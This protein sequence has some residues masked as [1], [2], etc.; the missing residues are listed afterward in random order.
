M[1]ICNTVGCAKEAV[2]SNREQIDNTEAMKTVFLSNNVLQVLVVCV[3]YYDKMYLS[4]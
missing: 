4:L 2:D 3:M 1:V